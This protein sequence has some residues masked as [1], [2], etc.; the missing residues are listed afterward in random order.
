[1]HTLLFAW[2]LCTALGMFLTQWW[3]A[4]R[5]GP[6]TC[7]RSECVP[8]W[9]S[10]CCWGPPGVC[11]CSTEGSA[12][13][14]CRQKIFLASHAQDFFREVVAMQPC[15]FLV[16]GTVCLLSL[17]TW[18]RE[19]AVLLEKGSSFTNG[20]PCLQ[21][22]KHRVWNRRNPCFL[23]GGNPQQGFTAPGGN[24]SLTTWS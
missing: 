3:Q 5:E 15:L 14:P 6:G 2:A 21:L 13:Q 20:C 7:C 23:V 12:R 17:Y 24:T 9:R 22:W 19:P 10:G 4:G 11:S 16:S 8:A 1:M 18:K